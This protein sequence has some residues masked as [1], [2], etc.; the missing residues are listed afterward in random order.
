[1]ISEKTLTVLKAAL[2]AIQECTHGE[3]GYAEDVQIEGM[4]EQKKAGYFSE[5]NKKGL[6]ESYEDR[7]V[8]SLLLPTAS[9]VEYARE[10]GYDK[11]KQFSTG[12]R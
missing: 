5:L 2:D 1:M 12:T 7:G 11:S 6:I 4:S 8:A 9:G 3:F 10:H